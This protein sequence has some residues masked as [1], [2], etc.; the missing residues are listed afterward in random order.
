MITFSTPPGRPASSRIFASASIDSGV[1][2]AGLTTIVQPGG[3]RRGDL[4]RAHRGGEVPGRHE[5]ARPDRLAHREDAALAG[6]VD[7]VAAVDAHGLLGEPAEE[8]GR[9]GDLRARLRQR[10]AHL[11]RHQQRQLVGLRD[12]RLV[13]PAQDLAALARR[14]G[15]PLGLRVGGRRQRR[16]RVLRLAR[17]P[18]PRAARSVAGS[19]TGE[20]AAAAGRAA[21]PRAMYRSVGTCSSTARSR[22]AT[23]VIVQH[24][25]RAAGRTRTRTMG[26]PAS[27]ATGR[28]ARVQ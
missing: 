22:V 17:R 4:A 6:G 1:C 8:L 15:R 10:L 2:W 16:Q 24:L 26:R 20:R 27:S 25:T 11:E 19:S 9:V 23:P 7:H 28:A 21:T 18:P 13:G 14:V 12:D 3:D 5:H